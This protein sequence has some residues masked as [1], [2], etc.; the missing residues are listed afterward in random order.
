G[1][2]VAYI[3]DADPVGSVP[4][5]ATLKGAAKAA[6][7]TMTG[8][9]PQTFLDQLGARLAFERTGTRLYE[10]LIT[11]CEAEGGNTVPVDQLRRFCDEEAHHFA[12]VKKCMEK[13]GADPTAQTPSADVGGVESMGLMQV[14]TDPKTTVAQSLHAILVAELADNAAWDELI[15]LAQKMGQ[16]DMVKEFT[17]AQQAEREHLSAVREWHEQ[18]TL[19]EAD[20]VKS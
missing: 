15:T 6:A 11:K 5:P 13:L 14:I 9:R 20:L 10:A 3:A 17:Q 4:P 2:R 8:K 12:L 18:L 16:D 19:A 7:K 1:M